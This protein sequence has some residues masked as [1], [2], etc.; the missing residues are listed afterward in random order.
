M[1]FLDNLVSDLIRKSTGFNA[2]PFVRAVGGRNV[3]L[4]GGAAIAGALAA[5]KMRGHPS[6]TPA[7]PPV[8]GAPPP[9]IP[10][11]P[12]AVPPI[13]VPPELLFAI[14]RCMVS[15]ALADGEMHAEEKKLI[16]SRLEES[17]LPV[18]RVKQIHKDL[19]IPPAP[20]EIVKGVATTE[21]R[22]LLFRFG[23]LV[24]RADEE[25]SDAE[26]AWLD[27][28]AKAAGISEERRKAIEDE[29]SPSP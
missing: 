25:A 5:E 27:R 11:T 1:A 22:E 28:L 7:V 12:E 2:R 13:P 23:W 3:L 8:P 24:V 6:P 21:D 15:G 20:E 10:A 26:R 9:P 14:V 16:E 4:L 17:G 29:I 19:V 18:E